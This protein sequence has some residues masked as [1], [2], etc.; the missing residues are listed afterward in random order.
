MKLVKSIP[1]VGGLPDIFVFYC[2]RCRQA[3]TRVLERAA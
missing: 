1:H 2:S 3:E